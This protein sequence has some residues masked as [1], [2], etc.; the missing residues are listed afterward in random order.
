MP[1]EESM[2][3]DLREI[4]KEFRDS[5]EYRKANIIDLYIMYN[6]ACKIHREELL[7]LYNKLKDKVH[8]ID[9]KFAEDRI[10]AF[11]LQG[12]IEI[13]EQILSNK[14]EDENGIL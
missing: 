4:E 5:G 6:G 9:P 2:M 12:A 7:K 14:D 10:K 11:K 3:Q 13:L 1:S 8:Y